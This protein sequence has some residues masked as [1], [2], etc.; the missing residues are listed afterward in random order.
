MTNRYHEGQRQ[1]QD[2]FDTRRLAD[3]LAEASND[4]FDEV[5]ATFISQRDMFFIASSDADGVPDCSYKGGDPGFVRVIDAATLA[6]PVFDGNGMFRTL[7]NLTVNPA[8]GLLFIDFETGSRLRVNGDARVDLDDPL[9][10]SYQGALCVVRVRARSIFANCRRY[11]HEYRK[12]SPSP[13]VPRDD[14]DPPV[15]DWKLDPWF[16]GTLPADDPAHDPQRPS[17]PAI[18]QF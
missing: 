12:V 11:V 16:D 7:G 4:T 18:P 10:A 15:P 3:R 14:V 8:V 5:T 9:A 2:L 1:F 6:F 13:F 17:A